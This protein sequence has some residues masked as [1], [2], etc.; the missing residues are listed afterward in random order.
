MTR[1]DLTLSLLRAAGPSGVTTA[2]LLQAG[3]GSRYGARLLELRELG[4]TITAEREREGSWRYILDTE[5]SSSPIPSPLVGDRASAPPEAKA[6]A[7]L[8][9]GVQ[10]G[11]GERRAACGIGSGPAPADESQAGASVAL[12]LFEMPA[13]KPA[14]HW[15]AV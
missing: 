1:R 8:G 15:E 13:A 9:S 14:Q 12:S 4:H 7:A 11:T 10:S 6:A 2:E 3:V 5:R